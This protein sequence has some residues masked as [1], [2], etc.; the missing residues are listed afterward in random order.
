MFGLTQKTWFSIWLLFSV[1]IGILLLSLATEVE[2]AVAIRTI[3]L[4]LSAS[5]I[6]LPL[7][8]S[9]AWACHGRGA[10][11]TALLITTIAT[12]LVPLFIHVSGWDAAFGK[13]GWLTSTRGQIL[14]PLVSGWTAA[15]WIHGIAAGPQVAMILLIGM[16]VGQ[17]VYEEQALL[18]T[19][20]S[21]VFWN[22]TI[23][24]IMPLLVLSTIWIVITCAREIAVTDLY[25]IGTLSEQIYL[26]YSLGLVST[27]GNWTAEQLA[28]AG[29]VSNLLAVVMMLWLAMFAFLFFFRL[30]DLE[31]ES[32][33]VEP[34]RRG[35]SSWQRTFIACLLIVLLVVVPIGNVIVRACFYV[36]PVDGIPTQG[37]SLNQLIQSVRRS[38]L[39]YQIEFGWS[40][41]IA[42]SSATL[43]V[44]LASVF[45]WNARRSRFVQALFALTLAFCCAI[46]G[47]FIGTSIAAAAAGVNNESFRWLYNY[48]IAAPVVANLV[49]CWPVGALVVW[50]IFRKIPLDALESSR[51][52]GARGATRFF[53]FGVMGNWVALTGCWL[54][55]FA[56][57]FGELSASQIVR[58]AG[59]DTVPRK[60][61]G[62][63]HAGVNELTA[64]IT[65]VTASMIVV[66][67]LT[68]WWFIRLNRGAIGRQ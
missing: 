34:Y 8:A 48:T 37:Y 7:G 45:A 50:F 64:G 53:R 3:G 6:A 11:S 47:P 42:C 54:I 20:S 66:V 40:F 32:Q 23:K 52:E 28:E 25:Q 22:V 10:A 19:N 67:S 60:M 57:S 18:D 56:C 63:L 21:G 43:I 15:T 1:V 12:L 24:R 31:Y 13:L 59:I 68:G 51:V 9:I 27:A 39:D 30:T 36:R 4:G 46:P 65:I 5:L 55:S 62:D 26:G 44:L 49:F 35:S 14:V 16:S 41:L 61:L 38:L 2:R 29:S 58:P 17:R 33:S